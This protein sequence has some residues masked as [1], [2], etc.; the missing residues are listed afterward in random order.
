MEERRPVNNNA[1]GWGMA[2]FIVLLALLCIAGATWMH[3]ET[4]C[5][6]RDPMCFEHLEPAETGADAEH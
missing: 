1:Q 4:Y 6:P 2:A 3:Y 5:D